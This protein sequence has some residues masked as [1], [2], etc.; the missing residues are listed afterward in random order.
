ML[1]LQKPISIKKDTASRDDLD[2]DFLR[3]SGIAYIE[4]LGSKLWTDYNT[5]D[6]GITLL[7]ALCYAITDLGQRMSLPVEALLAKEEE[8]GVKQFHEASAILGCSPVT[9]LDYRKLF[10]DVPGVRN[11]WLLKHDKKLYINTKDAK[12]SYRSFL[13]NSAYAHLKAEDEQV[14]SLNGLYDLV[15]DLDGTRSINSLRPELMKRYQAHRNLCEDLIHITEV[16]QHPVKVCAQIELNPEAD[17]NQVKAL[18][19]Q[20]IDSYF[21]PSIR[22]KTLKQLVEMGYESHEIFNGP[23]LENGFLADEEVQNAQL[24]TEVRQS[25]LIAIINTIEGVKNI[26]AIS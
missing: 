25:D 1:T 21:S 7:E 23:L 17:E 26:K 6:P 5:H 11:A 8:N 22:P 13:K 18:L 15:V 9:H 4:A 19:L 16:T 3:K 10:I 2:F 20:A 14:K 24:R 12:L